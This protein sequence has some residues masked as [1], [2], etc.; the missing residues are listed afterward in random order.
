MQLNTDIV[1]NNIY[2][3]K[4][5]LPKNKFDKDSDLYKDMVKYKIE[6]IELEIRLPI[7]YPYKAPFFRVI[8]P[9]FKYKTG[10]VTVGG[11]LCTELITQTGWNCTYGI[12]T[13]LK[14]IAVLMVDGGGRIDNESSKK[15]YGYDESRLAQERI[16]Q[17]YGWNK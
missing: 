10:H 7:E 3:W 9:I 5:L 1:K 12:K 2:V 11:A 8:K 17:R 4:A 16:N 13:C 15:E 14:N 6:H